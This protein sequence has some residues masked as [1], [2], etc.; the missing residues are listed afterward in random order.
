LD[1]IKSRQQPSCSVFYH[2]KVN[3]PIVLG[4]LSL[5]LRRAIHLDPKTEQIVGDEE[6]SRLSVPEYR[7]PWKFPEEYMQIGVG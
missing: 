5:K 1:C 4:N 2:H 6:A 3:V 7:D